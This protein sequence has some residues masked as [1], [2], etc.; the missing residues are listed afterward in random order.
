MTTRV[1]VELM[2]GKLIEYLDPDGKYV[3]NFSCELIE[4]K[5]DA[6]NKIIEIDTVDIAKLKHANHELMKLVKHAAH[7]LTIYSNIPFDCI[8]DY[9]KEAER[10]EAK[11]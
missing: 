4:E 6:L 7:D 8:I 2:D 10:Y 5:I 1:S 9:K 11:G 3:L